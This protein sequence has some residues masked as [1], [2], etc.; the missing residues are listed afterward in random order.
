MTK[1][2]TKEKH[3][4]QPEEQATDQDASR[5]AELEKQA[6]ELRLGW[7]RTQADFVNF[8][9]QT[10]QDRKRLIKLANSELIAR[11]LPVL[12]NFELATR[13]LPAELETNNWAIGIKF[14]EKQIFDI[15][16][17]EGLERIS[18]VGTQFNPEVHEAIEMVESDRPE[19]EVVE[20]VNSG[21]RFDG[22]LLR[23]A[24]VKVSIGYENNS[25]TSK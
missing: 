8:K 24:K 25:Q 7:Q 20:E 4:Q 9:R 10:E 14:I 6:E 12:D 2:M 23:P 16:E 19:N 3:E 17:N 21:Y 1:V 5:I 13:H 22:V 15:L 18:S 11:L